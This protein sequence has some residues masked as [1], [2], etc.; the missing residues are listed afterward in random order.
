MKKNII[1]IL[2]VFSSTIVF[3]QQTKK[4]SIL[5]SIEEY[6]AM[7][8]KDASTF[9]N[10]SFSIEERIKAIQKHAIIYDDNQKDQ[11]KRIV[12]SERET[13]EIRAMGL[14]KIYSEVDKD[15][16]FFDQIVLW[17]SNPKTPKILRDETL[18]LIGNLSFSSRPGIL[19][20]YHKMV[21]DPDKVYREF[22]FTKLVIN[23]D[24]R[25]QQL[26]I[27]GL[28]DANSRLI[29]PILSILILSSAPKKDFY[30]AVYKLMLETKNDDERL[31]A[32]ETIGGYPEAKNKLMSIFLSPE[33]KSKFR[34]SALIAF[35]SSNKQ[36]TTKYLSRLL[37]DTSASSALQILV[38]QIAINE[39]K[40]IAHRK[41]ANRADELDNLI[42][43]I[44]ENKGINNNNDQ[45]NVAKKYL[46]LIRPK[47]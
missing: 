17:F 25:A 24:S 12:L 2:L 23:G 11:F 18:S 26:L 29:D 6:R 32:I 39:K 8:F 27:K 1:L 45:V 28:E 41:K 30:P 43:A 36:E 15:E 16:K 37:L 40:A 7:V 3:A 19:D 21:E 22:V 33:E 47:F 35:Y 9:I 31:I 38:I 13:P 14:N 34:E 44:S 5:K 10:N 42:K 46:L 20:A 4:D